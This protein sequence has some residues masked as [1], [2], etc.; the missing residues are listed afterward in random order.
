MPSILEK[1]KPLYEAFSF[2]KIFFSKPYPNRV[3]SNIL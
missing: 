1:I 3:K 2:A